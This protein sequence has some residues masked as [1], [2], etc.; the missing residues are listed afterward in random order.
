MVVDARDRLRDAG[1]SDVHQVRSLFHWQEAALDFL[2]DKPAAAIF[3]GLGT[4]K[5]RIIIEDAKRKEAALVVVCPKSA[6]A[7]W[8]SQIEQWDFRGAVRVINYES[9]WRP[10]A[11][12]GAWITAT[13]QHSEPVML[14]LDESHK[15]KDRTTKQSKACRKLGA[16]VTFRRILSGTPVLNGYQDLWAQ[17]NFLIGDWPSMDLWKRWK[18]FADRHLVFNP[19]FPSKVELVKDLPTIQKQLAPFTFHIKAD[20]VLDLPAATDIYRTGALGK[21]GVEVYN[22]LAAS[23]YTHLAEGTLTAPNNLV[24]VLRLAEITGGFVHSDDGTVREVDTAK[25]ALLEEVLDEIGD[26]KAVI[27]CRFTAERVAIE[28]LC[29]R[30]GLAYTSL[31]GGTKNRSAVW[32]AG[33]Q[34]LVSMLQVGSSSIDLTEARY[35]VYYSVGFSFGDYEQSRGRI[36]RQGQSRP[37]FYVHLQLEDTIDQHI[38]GTLAHKGSV[39]DA[40]KSWW[41]GRR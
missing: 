17:M 22:E 40:V 11:N 13:R 24:K 30:K 10:S 34:V 37:Q 8:R 38:Y 23:F 16:D 3:A 7:V 36:R 33:F 6:L 20:D 26:E 18:T 31:H 29:K 39:S 27:F 41:G 4:G 35:A 1:V 21:Y 14:V 2:A 32:P 5:T 25:L 9:V 28:A 19:Y 12:V 15:I